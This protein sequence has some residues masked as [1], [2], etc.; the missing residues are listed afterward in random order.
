[1]DAADPNRFVHIVT[2]NLP[3][4]R[5]MKDK[6]KLQKER[7]VKTFD[8]GHCDYCFVISAYHAEIQMLGSMWAHGSGGRISHEGENSARM[9]KR[10]RGVFTIR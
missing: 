2:L 8:E 10:V 3:G 5:G 6:T 1:M 4:F 9:K 7:W